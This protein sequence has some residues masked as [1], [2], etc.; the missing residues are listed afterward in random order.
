MNAMPKPMKPNTGTGLSLLKAQWIMP[1]LS[2]DAIE[3]VARRFDLPEPL[4]RILLSRDIDEEQIPAFIA[5]TLREHLPD[6]LTMAGMKEAAKDIAGWIADK[7]SISIFADF[8][9]DGATS[10][11]VLYRFLKHCGVTPR[12]YIPERLT[13]GYGPNVEAMK[14]LKEEGSE[15]VIMLDC[16]TAGFESVAAAR[17]LGLEVVIIDH[18]EPEDKLPLATHI[19]NPKRRDDMSGLAMLAAVGVTFMT[20]IAVNAALRE[21][22]FYKGQGVA[23]APLKDFLDLVALGTVCDMVPLTGVNRLLVRQG[24]Q[25]MNNTSNTGLRK[26]AEMARIE[27]PYTPYHAGFMLG[28]RINAGSRVHKSDLGA[29]LLCLGDDKEEEAVSIAF[30]LEDCNSRRKDIQAAMERSAMQKAETVSE[31][32]VVIVDGQ[33]WHQGL[34][35]LV[36]GRLKDHYARPACVIAYSEGANGEREA[37]GSARSIPGIHI[38]QALMDARQAGVIIKGGGHAMAGGFTLSPAQ[39]PAFKTFMAAHVQRQMDEMQSGGRSLVEM[40]IDALITVQGIRA[41]LL[42]RIDEILGPFGQEYPEPLFLLRNVRIH[43]ADVLNGGHVRTL[44]SDWEGGVRVKAMAFRAE[45]NALGQALL[46]QGK[47]SF[48]LV[49]LLKLNTW[50]GQERAE[51]HIKD[52]AFSTAG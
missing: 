10:A 24:F 48:D 41:D 20:C 18:H 21:Q 3:R 44:I 40:R 52:A 25:V 29:Q 51:I 26:L 13:E 15:I 32:P 6:P 19:I 28:P 30:T 49:G 33:D 12:V 4:V 27:P 42:K 31:G 9:V 43:S 35:G 36:A 5:P 17:A 38:A 37:R 14:T 11:A 23:E 2:W 46:T 22:G 47:R 34:S 8:D 45:H 7:K 39:L 50:Q 16:G 1:D